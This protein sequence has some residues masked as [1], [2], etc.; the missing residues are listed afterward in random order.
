[1]TSVVGREFWVPLWWRPFTI[2]S[3]VCLGTAALAY[4]A[5]LFFRH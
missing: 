1:V 3:T 2:V 4:I 5:V